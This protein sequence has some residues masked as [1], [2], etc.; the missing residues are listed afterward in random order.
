MSFVSRLLSRRAALLAP[1]L[2]ALALCA[3]ALPAAAQGNYPSRPIRLVIPFGA[4]GITDVVGRLIGQQLG[5]ELKQPVIIDNRAG[6]GG[7]IAAQAVAQ[8][9]PDGYTLL[10][11]TVGTQVVNK[12]IYSKLAYDPAAFAP[13]SLVSNSPYMLAI[14]DIP[15]VN[16]LQGL[17]AYAHAHPGQLN[18]GSAGNGSSPHLGIEL[19]KLSTRSYI[20]HIPFKSGAEAVNAALA[21]QVQIVIDAIPVIQ[22]Q[23]KAGRLK[24]LA[25]AD[26]RRNAAVPDLR[27][28]AEQGVPGFQIG[29]W[30]AIVAPQ[31][32]PAAVVE[33]L[34]AALGRVLAR[35]EVVARLAELGIEPMPAGVAA[36][37]KHLQAETAKWSRVTQAAG[38]KLD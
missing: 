4:G 18:F 16:D 22:P 6:A 38:T 17:V 37:Q 36:Y 25:I 19:L 31:G 9:A 2:G 35:P 27:T 15:G 13:V 3:A 8:A 33:V 5:E 32:T 10:L 12:M 28:S 34:S 1:A 21:G 23:V 29:S 11:A 14:G 24:A 7:S 26:A 20:V 30:N